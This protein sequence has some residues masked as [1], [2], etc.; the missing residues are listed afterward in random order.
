VRGFA[1]RSGRR[2]A[3]SVRAHGIRMSTLRGTILLVRRGATT[4]HAVG[5][6]KR[7]MICTRCKRGSYVAL[8]GRNAVF[9]L[10]VL[11]GAFVVSSHPRSRMQSLARY[12]AHGRRSF[13]PKCGQWRFCFR[14]ASSCTA[15]RLGRLKKGGLWDN[16]SALVGGWLGS[17][18][19]HSSYSGCT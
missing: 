18:F 8:T 1:H 12:G 15:V 3:S 16:R 4:Q 6:P 5:R 19:Y 7:A 13:V 2:L 9:A 10:I 14:S 17:R 11:I